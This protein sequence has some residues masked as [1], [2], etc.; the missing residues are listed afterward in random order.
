MRGRGNPPRS[1]DLGERLFAVA[2]ESLQ[3]KPA[4]T[5]SFREIAVASIRVGMLWIDGLARLT[6]AAGLA[7]GELDD[8]A[9]VDIARDIAAQ[10]LADIR[11][12]GDK[13]DFRIPRDRLN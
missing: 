5:D 1:R 10:Q 11:A 13:V 9:L 4:T 7:E 3:G 12:K 6:R 8:A 2:F